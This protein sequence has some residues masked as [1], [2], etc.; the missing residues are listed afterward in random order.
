MVEVVSMDA[1]FQESLQTI[2]MTPDEAPKASIVDFVMAVTGKEHKRVSEVIINLVKNEAFFF[3]NC[4]RFQFPGARQ[5]EQYV[6]NA[7]QCFEL[8]MMLPGKNA[9]NFRCSVCSIVT[10]VFAGDPTLHDLIEKNG[11]SQG[12]IQQF[13]KSEVQSAVGGP[14]EDQVEDKGY[15][16]I[17]VERFRPMEEQYVMDPAEIVKHSERNHLYLMTESV[18]MSTIETNAQ[19]IRLQ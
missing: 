2:R 9:K 18:R 7:S 11:L 13:A 12:A 8:A 6:L 19:Q 5:K 14:I 15:T 17:Q 16:E 4:K 1:L 10:R 3:G